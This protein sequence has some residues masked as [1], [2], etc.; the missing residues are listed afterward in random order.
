MKRINTKIVKD[1]SRRLT[2]LFE[3][4]RPYES[5]VG[6]TERVWFNTEISNDGHHNVGHTKAYVKVLVPLDGNLPGTSHMVRITAC[7]RFHVEGVIVSS[8]PLSQTQPLASSVY[9]SGG[10]C[11]PPSSSASASSSSSRLTASAI[12]LMPSMD[13]DLNMVLRGSSA[14]GRCDDEDDVGDRGDDVSWRS[15]WM[16]WSRIERHAVVSGGLLTIA[17]LLRRLHKS[18]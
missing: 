16:M 10:V 7:Q 18:S 9:S 17:L 11:A 6:R 8:A 12:P 4:F 14:G 1:R 2:H 15:M 3:G 13:A 5:Y